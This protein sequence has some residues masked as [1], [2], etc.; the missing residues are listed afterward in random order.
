MADDPI[1][2][3]ALSAEK[4]FTNQLT[5]LHFSWINLNDNGFISLIQK[6]KNLQ[7]IHLEQ[8]LALSDRSL[9]A[10]PLNLKVLTLDR[11]NF[12]PEA[13]NRNLPNLKKLRIL[14]LNQSAVKFCTLHE[15][16]YKFEDIE[17]LVVRNGHKI[18]LERFNILK[19]AV[20][21][22]N[23]MLKYTNILSLSS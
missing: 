19:M 16:I 4:L 6:Q 14:S 22:R 9:D 7:K 5:Q 18:Q 20:D 2:L 13:L 12:N 21:F 15:M 23:Q 11:D 10:I 1:G 17:F 8:S 3:T